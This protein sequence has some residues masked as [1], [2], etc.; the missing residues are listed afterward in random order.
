MPE[1]TNISNT[2]DN[3]QQIVINGCT[4]EI[5]AIFSDKTKLEDIIARRVMKDFESENTEQ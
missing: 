3:V 1:E 5:R 2:D 4:Y